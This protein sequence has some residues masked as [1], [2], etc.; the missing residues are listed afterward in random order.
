M[1][2][3]PEVETI[4]R[5]LQSKV[6]GETI[7]NVNVLHNQVIE[8]LDAASY[9]S[10][11]LGSTL[12]SFARRGKYIIG[13]LSTPGFI[14]IHLRMTGQLHWTEPA[15]P[16]LP[17]T[18]LI[19]TMTSG[20]ELRYVDIRRFGKVR[21]QFNIEEDPTLACL[22]TEPFD[23]ELTPHSFHQLLQRRH[24][25]VKAI[26]LDQSILAGMGN[27]Y[28]D[29]ALFTAGLHPER[30]ASS[31]SEEECT[32]LLR[33]IR[34]V[35]EESIT[36]RGSSMR[37]YCNIDGIKGTYQEMWRVYRQTGSPCPRCGNAIRRITVRGRSSH[38]CPVC[39]PADG[40]LR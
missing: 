19:F 22:G 32:E 3:L 9:R 2:E 36:H 29:E 24:S 4:C 25:P 5:A 10:A 7:C 26:L 16:L 28:A 38:F 20:N 8:P 23:A 18:H 14:I 40:R 27:I 6:K 30:H 31:L 39:Q 33:A 17:H 34:F 35:L 21:Y 11:L 15:V 1:P 12:T 37:D 13:T